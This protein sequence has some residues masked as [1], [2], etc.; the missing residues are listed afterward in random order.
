MLSMIDIILPCLCNYLDDD[1]KSEMLT[2][3]G[4][5]EHLEFLSV[6]VLI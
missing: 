2:E 5:L 1:L 6:T 4:I 3:F